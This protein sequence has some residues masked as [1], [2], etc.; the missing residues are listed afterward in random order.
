MSLAKTFGSVLHYPSW[1][2]I[3]G[4]VIMGMLA[5]AHIVL[6]RCK[7]S[8][9][10]PHAFSAFCLIILC[11]QYL[12]A[13]R[14]IDVGS[15]TVIAD[16]ITVFMNLWILLHVIFEDCIDFSHKKAITKML[17]TLILLIPFLMFSIMTIPLA[18]YNDLSLEF[19][20]N[21]HNGHAS[22]DKNPTLWQ[23]T[24]GVA[25][26]SN[27]HITFSVF[28]LLFT[29][30]L[31]EHKDKE[32]I[33][34]LLV[35]LLLS[36]FLTALNNF[37]ILFEVPLLNVIPYLLAQVIIIPLDDPAYRVWQRQ[38]KRDQQQQQQQQKE[39]Q[40]LNTC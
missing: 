3:F 11:I 1:L 32:E 17:L 25:I 36:S 4:S 40:R 23:I 8:N 18:I 33:R 15:L 29:G 24:L 26:A 38:E 31:K 10:R 2:L 37:G 5:R 35:Y 22:N 34:S 9:L 19:S 7:E 13:T 28:I 16:I 27:L 12:L 6:C 30:C 14:G 21:G 39:K 20:N